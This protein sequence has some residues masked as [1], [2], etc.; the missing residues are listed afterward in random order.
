[1]Y[2]I[3]LASGQ[4]T[5]Y[6]SID[7]LTH[8]V[9]SGEVTAEALIYHQ[10]A[11]RW[12]SITNHPHYQIAI[13]R[14]KTGKVAIP[15]PSRRQVVAAVKP[16]APAEPTVPPTAAR[17]QLMDVVAEMDRGTQRPVK[18]VSIPTIRK[19]EE[20]P[21]IQAYENVIEGVKIP[22]PSSNPAGG[23]GHP[24]GT[25]SSNGKDPRTTV[26]PLRRAAAP[27]SPP[28]APAVSVPDLGNGLELV[29]PEPV[30]SAVSTPQVD[31]LLS[32]LEPAAPARPR[33]A[34]VAAPVATSTAVEER[35]VEII[36][37]ESPRAATEYELAPLKP[38]ALPRRR[39]RIPLVAA[40][41]VVLAAGAGIVFWKT[42]RVPPPQTETPV[43]VVPA[44]P[45]TDAFGGMTSIDTSAATV[46]AP[47]AVPAAARRDTAVRATADS[48][49]RIVSV[50]AP[51]VS[52][53][54]PLPT[55][56]GAI[57]VES[58][59]HIDIPAVTLIQ[60]YTAAY[61]DA[62][63]EME[64]RMLQLGFTQMFLRNRLSTASG[65]EDSRRLVAA[66]TAAI[67]QYRT[68]ETRIERAYADTVGPAGRNL[69]WSAR[70]LGTWN[71]RTSPRENP[72]TARLTNLMLNQMDDVF[73]LLL[74]QDGK[75]RINGDGIT[76]DDPEAARK[77]G[78]LRAW[79]NQQA[80]N[81]AGTADAAMP[82]TLR[83]VVKGIGASRLP[84]E[85]P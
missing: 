62:R 4:E 46:E 19:P 81:Y 67:R 56:L 5:T 66:A 58:A 61:A 49:E 11:D 24:N 38:A 71:V 35:P 63:G 55:D 16:G 41:V 80:D 73:Q 45:R 12:L 77:Y 32:L 39:N 40:A 83:Q 51:R 9:H 7:E 48:D 85:R 3:K 44:E 20:R 31:K 47:A 15:D 14:V 43:A 18:R 84:R 75:Y 50:A 59:S 29:E 23:N 70:E 42:R 13:N 1:M 17:A 21:R 74:E 60:H 68:A 65:L 27:P 22:A 52:L 30:E 54:A 36:N 76:F 8:A 79:L 26:L 69:G 33:P 78:A 72:E 53:K 37:L 28:P 6:Q 82:A 64:L 25:Q 57:Q 2:R 34:P 10:R